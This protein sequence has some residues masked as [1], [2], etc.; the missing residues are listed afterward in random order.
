MKRILSLLLC[1]AFAVSVFASCTDNGSVE[2][3]Q[4]NNSAEES[5]SD[6]VQTDFNGV[7]IA[8]IPLDNRPVNKER[9]EYLAAAAGFELLVPDEQLY[10]TALD[11]MEPNKNGLTYGDRTALLEWLKSVEDECDYYVI[12][13]D[14]MFSGGLVGS[15]WLQNTDLTLETEIADYLIGLSKDNYV[16]YFDTVMRLAS[17]VGYQGYQLE[18]YNSFREYGQKARKTLTGSEL[19]VD[20]I[21]AGYR[22]DKNGRE[23]GIDVADEKLD[24]YLASR[25]RKL[26]VID[27]LLSRASDDIERLYV[28]VDDSNPQVTIQTNEINYISS[29]AGK[30]FTLFA[31]A[32]ELGLMGVAAITSACYGNADC[33]VTYFGEGKDQPADAYDTGTLSENVEKHLTSIGATVESKDKNALQVLVLTKSFDLSANADKLITQMKANLQAGVPTCII[34]TS[35]DIGALSEKMLSADCDIAMLLGYSHWNTVGNAVGI[36]VSNAVARYLY[37][38]NST[39]VTDESHK[40]FLKSLTFSLIKDISYKYKGYTDLG[41]PSL[42]GAKNIVSLINAS[43]MMSAKGKAIEHP[44]V[45]VSNFRYPWDRAFEATFDITVG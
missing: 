2:S 30:N 15:R 32:D 37:L 25:E 22:Y 39:L 9:V 7:K 10:R 24:Q 13:L 4:S 17:T 18:E 19:T 3:T 14:Q 21:V 28:G 42:C 38:Y 12:S 20:N 43:K 36:S 35:G 45:S 26:R 40:G 29:L 8:Y 31:G 33:N 23:I 6:G 27:Y 44:S 5:H 1:I 11:N 16:V 34:N 41:E